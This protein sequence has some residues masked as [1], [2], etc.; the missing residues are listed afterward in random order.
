MLVL[1]R[2][3]SRVTVRVRVTPRAARDAIAGEREGTLLVRVTAP[4]VE[5]K[6]NHA[7]AA[8]LARA[9]DLAPG[10][11]RIERGSGGRTKLL[12]LPASAEVRLARLVK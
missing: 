7:V 9:L 12:S 8:L 11:V 1:R 3:R 4:P 6:A 5:G 2:A 10:E